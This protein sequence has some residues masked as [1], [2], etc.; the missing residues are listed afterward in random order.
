M[1]NKLEQWF[2]DYGVRRGYDES[3]PDHE[4]RKVSLGHWLDPALQSL[5]RIGAIR[6][7][8]SNRG[9]IAL[10][11]PSQTGKST[12]LSSYI[13][14]EQADGKDGA[15]TWRQDAPVRFSPTL[16]NDVPGGTL[17]FN[18]YNHN[19]DASGVAT[20]YTLSGGDHGDVD[21]L[22]PVSMKLATRAQIIHA[23]SLGYF[24]EC[25][26]VG[27]SIDI[28]QDAF[29]E[30]I[31]ASSDAIHAP[32]KNAY[33]L[34]KDC[35]D[36][37]S[38]MRNHH[39]FY[40][41]FR[42]GDWER[43][44]RPALVSAD[45]FVKNQ[46]AAKEFLAELFW[47]G[48]REISCLFDEIMALRDRL[49]NLW[50]NRK[51]MLT[52][53][54][55]SLL[56]DIDT[57]RNF[58][59][60]HGDNGQSIADK[61]A[62]LDWE[63]KDDVVRVFVGSRRTEIGGDNFGAFQALC[64]ELNV[65]LR[66]AALDGDRKRPFRELIEKC[67]IL[68]L[69]GLSNLNTGGMA[70]AETSSRIDVAKAEKTV[71]LTRMFKEG[72]TQSF[73][74]GY[75]RSYGVDAF[76]ILV[77]SDR[78][79]SKSDLLNAGITEW[80]R[81]FDPE[82]KHGSATEMP[83]FIDMTFFGKVL[84]DVAMNGVGNGLLPIVDRIQSQLIFANKCSSKWFTTN[85]AQFPDGA[86]SAP[87]KKDAV[88]S[89]IAADSSFMPC[90]GI[91]EDG[92]RSVYDEDGG[93]GFMLKAIS[94]DF[95][96]GRRSVRCREILKNDAKTLVELIKRQLPS[97][98]DNDDVERRSALER[99]IAQLSQCVNNSEDRRD[100]QELLATARVL[101]KIF[102]ATPDMFDPVPTK[103]SDGTD[104][105]QREYVGRQVSKWFAS[106]VANIPTDSNLS[107]EDLTMLLAVLRD[108]VDVGAC[109][110]FLSQGGLGSIPDSRTAASARYPLALL[111]GN[112][113]RYGQP[114]AQGS[115]LPGERQP[116]RL[117]PMLAASEKNY[118][119]KNSPY[120]ISII[121][122]VCNRLNVLMR[123][124]LGGSRPPQIG[125]KELA[126]ILAEIA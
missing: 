113:L 23:L 83:V 16:N 103:F 50:G 21:P 10:W 60:P 3:D 5:D 26:P 77:R 108:S 63:I 109:V 28:T 67:D 76:I 30:K 20:R 45:A 15:L 82:W 39:R 97:D 78:P 101:K 85:Y 121:E 125:D 46:T 106:Q 86:V 17:I 22:Y 88:V 74:Y 44:I 98:S 94:D 75:V 18:P 90:T 89:A 104:D 27:D 2:W 115:D 79:P 87:G 52:Q 70:G 7:N 24:S 48:S 31:E 33:S 14:G 12:L 110:E 38:F 112:L 56:L 53:E 117:E 100:G 43:K 59:A 25:A 34:L 66:A 4:M 123:N 37:I 69:P 47:D 36:V 40:H 6:K 122:P 120:N 96:R 62:N 49:L 1:K 58:V 81:A 41:L 99:I 68:D 64:G 80:L 51:I 72:K 71:L 102:S 8:D 84:N 9:C 13:D 55:A 93:V 92:L 57:Y 61:V 11:G 91:D 116:Q 124:G 42:R 111:M 29:M 95:D 107:A 73:V 105:Q 118:N 19:S 65:P 119:P 54:A 126:G 114:V 32:D 35:A